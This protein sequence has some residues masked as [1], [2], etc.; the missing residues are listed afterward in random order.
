MPFMLNIQLQLQ[1]SS[2]L[3]GRQIVAHSSAPVLVLPNSRSGLTALPERYHQNLMIHRKQ[4]KMLNLQWCAWL[5]WHWYCT[6][7]PNCL[8]W[9]RHFLKF[10][11]FQSCVL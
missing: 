8:R 2:P 1:V 10:W 11:K 3:F 4:Q 7:N 9:Q 5:A 6:F